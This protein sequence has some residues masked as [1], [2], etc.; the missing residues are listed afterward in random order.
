MGACDNCGK[1]LI[2]SQRRFCGS[3]CKGI[4]YYKKSLVTVSC[5]C[6]RVFKVSKYNPST[7]KCR[8]CVESEK[9][10]SREGSRNAAWRGGHRHW[11]KGKLGRDKDG[12]SWKV[13]R[14]LAWERDNYTCQDCGKHKVGWKPNVHHVIPYRI[15]S[16]HALSN[17]KCLCKR[18]HKIA[19]AKI[20]ELWV[21]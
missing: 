7:G 18:C 1:V 2:G 10:S 12:L 15:S 20:K 11:V 4:F 17:L 21:G 16:S 3:I 8:S 13:Q 9:A 14:K 19:E 6:G 5:V